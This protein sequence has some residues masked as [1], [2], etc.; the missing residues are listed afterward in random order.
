MSDEKTGTIFLIGFMGSGKSTVGRSLSRRLLLPFTDTDVRIEKEQGKSISDIFAQDGEEAFRWME[1]QALRSISRSQLPQ[2]V[3]TG[4][5][6]PMRMENRDILKEAGTTVFLRVRPETVYERLHGDTS[7]PLLQKVDPEE[8]IRRL[9]DVRNPLYEEAADIIVDVDGKTP[10]ELAEE[11]EA[12]CAE[13]TLSAD[14]MLQVKKT[15]QNGG[16]Q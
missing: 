5:G 2:V 12:A 7:R 4:G 10:K 14:K 13:K 15:L 9:L 6:L 16:N 11:I 1:T 3:S 8:E